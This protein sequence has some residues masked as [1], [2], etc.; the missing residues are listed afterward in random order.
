MI[1]RLIMRH[2]RRFAPV[3]DLA[4][5]GYRRSVLSYDSFDQH[6]AEV[7]DALASELGRVLGA[8]GTFELWSA[9]KRFEA[10]F[11]RR[12]GKKHGIGVS[13]GTAALQLALVAAGVGPGDEVITS[14]HTFIATLLAIHNT[15]ARPVLVDPHPLDLCVRAEAIAA[16]LSVRTRA[17]VPVH[18][19]G[20]VA[21]MPEILALAEAR[22]L[23]V[24]EDCAQAHGAALGVRQVPIGATGCFSF[25]AT[26]PLGGAGNGGMIVTD[27]D[28][29][30]AVAERIR[31]P[32]GDD[33]RILSAART[34]SY[35]NALEAA[36]L[37]A[38]LPRMDAWRAARAD[39]AQ[40]YLRALPHL[41]PVVPRSEVASAW[42]SFVVR[43]AD[44][45]SVKA[46]LLAAGVETRVEY[47]N[48][49]V[50]SPTFAA[51][52]W[53]EADYP[54]AMAAADHGLSLPVH[55]FLRPEERGRVIAALAGARSR[56]S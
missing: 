38:R 29:L 42:Y 55:A 56:R 47:A 5:M 40:T 45:D 21:G 18:M 4:S 32:E 46:R 24:I 48:H 34:P 39:N 33:A 7:K 8:R 9:S 13:S 35:L 2:Y 43:L 22:G 12:C 44:R 41:A 3:L 53:N 27:D 17:I 36:V 15:G 10:E 49:F 31:D 6:N 52:G 28:G 23:V 11:A 1:K 54:V 25:Y 16:A 26:K 14:A 30:A 37:A 50:R 19:H 20:H 51:M